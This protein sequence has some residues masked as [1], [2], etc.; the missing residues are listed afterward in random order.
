[1][2]AYCVKRLVNTATKINRIFIF[3]LFVYMFANAL[4]EHINIT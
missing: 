3:C 4:M 2:P 1:M